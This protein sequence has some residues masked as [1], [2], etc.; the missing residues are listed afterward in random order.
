VLIETD[1]GEGPGA[2]AG[3]VEGDQVESRLKFDWHI[4]G[5]TV[6]QMIQQISIGN[7]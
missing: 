1:G 2:L 3:H 4:L 6:A 7:L 5:H